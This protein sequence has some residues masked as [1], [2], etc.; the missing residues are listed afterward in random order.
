MTFFKLLTKHLPPQTYEQALPRTIA[1]LEG[2][3]G[4]KMGVIAGFYLGYG[5]HALGTAG[6]SDDS[7]EA[8]GMVL[9]T[10]STLLGGVGGGAIAYK[11]GEGS[12][13][14]YLA[15]FPSKKQTTSC[16]LLPAGKKPQACLFLAC[17]A[18]DALSAGYKKL[19]EKM[20]APTSSAS[21]R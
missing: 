15:A 21:P 19:Q 12:A 4:A 13:N 6:R 5:I 10:A 8:K 1:T 14:L 11:I 7:S 3:Y 16:F 18:F 17:L 20:D 9:T 2:Y